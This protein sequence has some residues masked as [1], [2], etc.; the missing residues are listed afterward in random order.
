MIVHLAPRGLVVRVQSLARSTMH[1]NCF[2]VASGG[3]LHNLMR[4]NFNRR[5]EN[6]IYER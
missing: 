3:V 4:A 2:R 5:Q 6:R 1:R